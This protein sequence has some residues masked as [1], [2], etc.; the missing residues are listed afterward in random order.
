MF[1]LQRLK[2]WTKSSINDDK[3]EIEI[4]QLFQD[5]FNLIKYKTEEYIS[6]CGYEDK[7]LFIEYNNELISLSLLNTLK[8]S[9]LKNNKLSIQERAKL[10]AELTNF[11]NQKLK[12]IEAKIIELSFTEKD[13]IY[14]ITISSYVQILNNLLKK[15]IGLLA[16]QRS[17]V[18][19]INSREEIQKLKDSI[20]IRTAEIQTR[21][22]LEE[23]SKH[24]Y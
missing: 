13:N 18:K 17:G 7:R 19:Y 9:S 2:N 6:E 10:A 15:Y 5:Q 12:E 20:E 1:N 4:Y 24:K 22:S 14:L 23:I 3:K 16:I 11:Y 8:E 21:L